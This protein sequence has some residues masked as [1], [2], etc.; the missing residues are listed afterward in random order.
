M[1]TAFFLGDLNAIVR[2]AAREGHFLQVVT[3]CLFAGIVLTF[4]YGNLAYFLSRIGALKRHAAYSHELKKNASSIYDDPPSLTVLV[5]SFKEEER[6]VSRALLSAALAEY[7]A[8]SIVLL[9]DD[10]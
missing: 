7:P 6:V 9:I 3:A 10:D 5:P 4:A 2:A 8:K 1:S